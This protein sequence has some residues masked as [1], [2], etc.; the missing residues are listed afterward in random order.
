VIVQPKL[1]IASVVGALAAIP[2][3]ALHFAPG[4]A[5]YY[6]FRRFVGRH[7]WVIWVWSISEPIWFV[8][9]L[10][11]AGYSVSA[12]SLRLGMTPND[13]CPDKDS[14]ICVAGAGA[15][16]GGVFGAF[17]YLVFWVQ[18]RYIVI[19]RRVIMEDHICG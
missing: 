14:V 19:K 10:A 15:A 2:V 1:I 16:A 12:V 8:G 9:W 11:L 3:Y 6:R 18:R 7:D 13:A 5:R 17:Q 4:S